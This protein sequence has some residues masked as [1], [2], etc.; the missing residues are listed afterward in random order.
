MG[1]IEKFH[2][3]LR[4]IGKESKRSSIAVYFTLRFLVIICMVLEFLRGDI[5]NAML[6]LLSLA[7]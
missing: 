5:N 2:D 1:K 4:R 3:E 6:C 7:L